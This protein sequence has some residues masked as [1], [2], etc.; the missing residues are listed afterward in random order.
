MNALNYKKPTKIALLF[1][2]A[3]A[4]SMISGCNSSSSDDV[5]DQVDD[6]ADQV[7]DVADQVDDNG[8]ADSGIVF[9]IAS[10]NYAGITVDETGLLSGE[11]L[12]AAQ[13]AQCHGTYGVA[14]RE[15][16]DLWG[17]GRQIGQWM[18]DYQD[19][20]LYSD[21]MMY[22]HALA[23]T[24]EEVDLLKSYYPKVTY[25]KDAVEGE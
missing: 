17:S 23:Y 22:I 21:N 19:E 10:V 24:S 13:C 12:L 3:F 11:R 20:T 2:A 9:N 8:V 16:P 1:I 5:A 25:D 14:V 6:V 7:D 4:I 15:W 18:E